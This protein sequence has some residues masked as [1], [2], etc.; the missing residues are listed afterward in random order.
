MIYDPVLCRGVRKRSLPEP[1]PTKVELK[2]GCSYE[3]VLSVAASIFFEEYDPIV[4]ILSLA[5]SNGLP[6]HVASPETWTV[7]NFYQTNALQPSRYKL[8][9][10][11]QVKYYS[12]I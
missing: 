10:V 6:I 9:V 2:W 1:N 12:G 3:D 7:G 5:D 8:Y 4:D 11:L